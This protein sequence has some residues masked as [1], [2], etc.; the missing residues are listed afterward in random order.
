[1]QASIFHNKSN[2]IT[3]SWPVFF[4]IFTNVHSCVRMNIDINVHSLFHRNETKP[5]HISYARC[6]PVLNATRLQA[7]KP[8]LSIWTVSYKPFNKRIIH[9]KTF[10]TTF[11]SLSIVM[12][13]YA[14]ALNYCC[15]QK[16][17][18]HA[19]RN[20]QSRTKQLHRTSYIYDH[21]IYSTYMLVNSHCS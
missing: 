10:P 19:I 1:M 15:C 7:F 3:S 18:I 14:I 17:Y 16:E 2:E 5:T 12:L 20:T 9:V 21:M 13:L 11:T 4:S 8:K 6:I